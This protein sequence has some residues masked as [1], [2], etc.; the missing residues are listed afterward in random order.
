VTAIAY[1]LRMIVDDAD[2]AYHD[3]APLDARYD[4]DGPWERY[5]RRK[6]VLTRTACSAAEYE[7]ELGRI[8]DEEG[9]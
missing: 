7:R 3:Q 1:R 6:A 4:G 8:A 9:V 2:H 5:E